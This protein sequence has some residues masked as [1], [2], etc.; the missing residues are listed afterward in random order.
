MRY[1]IL[2]LIAI[3]LTGCAVLNIL[4]PKRPVA[5]I[6][7]SKQMDMSPQQ[8]MTF[9]EKVDTTESILQEIEKAREGAISS[10]V[11]VLDR[12]YRVYYIQ[13][14]ASAS[15]RFAE[16]VRNRFRQEF[17]DKY[18]VS[19]KYVPPLYRVRV[20]GFSSMEEAKK[21]L[22]EIKSVSESYRDAFLVEEIAT[23]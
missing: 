6:T 19:I 10:V 4:T 16:K 20:G 17:G 2:S 8:V 1:A 9:K 3:S 15:K 18:P 14:Y 21:A 11:E 12:N 13:I 7:L 5:V 23:E 22:K